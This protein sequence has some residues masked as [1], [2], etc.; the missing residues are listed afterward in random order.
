MVLSNSCADLPNKRAASFLFILLSQ[1]QHHLSYRQEKISAGGPLWQ[2]GMEC[3]DHW[4]K[5]PVFIYVELRM[6]IADVQRLGCFFIMNYFPSAL[7]GK[8][9]K[10]A[11]IEVKE[12]FRFV[13]RPALTHKVVRNCSGIGCNDQQQPFVFQ[14]RSCFAQR[15]L[16][17]RTCSIRSHMTMASK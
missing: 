3:I 15:F 8:V 9:L 4:R 12:M 14:Q 5:Q 7:I 13:V 6:K 17:R 10:R 1:Y 2:Q 16:W 11:A